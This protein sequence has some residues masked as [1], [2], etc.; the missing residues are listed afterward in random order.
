M[1]YLMVKLVKMG[2]KFLSQNRVTWGLDTSIFSPAYLV[3]L[4]EAIY[5]PRVQNNPFSYMGREGEPNTGKFGTPW[6]NWPNTGVNPRKVKFLVSVH[7]ADLQLVLSHANRLLMNIL[8]PS[9]G[10]LD[11]S[12]KNGRTLTAVDPSRLDTEFF[13][14][15]VCEVVRIEIDVLGV[16]TPWKRTEKHN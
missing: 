14:V 8:R 6:H 11:H 7:R 13:R 2:K 10:R 9:W 4:R 1:H 16:E 12:V 3:E 5:Y 15:V